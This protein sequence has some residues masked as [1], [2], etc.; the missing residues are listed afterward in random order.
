MFQSKFVTY[1]LIAVCS[2]LVAACGGAAEPAEEVSAYTVIREASIDTTETLPRAVESVL[3]L[4]G[5]I[6][7]DKAN[8]EDGTLEID[9]DTLETLE[10]VEV[11]PI[12]DYQATGEE[13]TAQ[14]VLLSD[15]LELAGVPEDAEML[16]LTAVDGYSVEM[17]VSD[18]EAYDVLLATQW[19][20]E[21][22]DVSNFGPVRIVYPYHAYELEP[23]VYDPRWIWSVAEIDVE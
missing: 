14:G 20:G 23:E 21:Y 7:P 4:S 18:A 5:N 12:D 15:V 11:T 9:I 16:T 1:M 3:T 2:V 19:N 8:Q 13:S 17:P 22:M 10:L 6:D